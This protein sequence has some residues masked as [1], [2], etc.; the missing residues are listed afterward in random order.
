MYQAVRNR[1][2]DRAEQRAWSPSRSL[3]HQRGAAACRRTRARREQH[4]AGGGDDRATDLAGT[5]RPAQTA[6]H[7]P[8]DQ[9]VDRA[10][11]PSDRVPCGA[12]VAAF[13][14]DSGA[15]ETR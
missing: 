4:R 15:S 11:V 5:R 3:R 7:D 2:R 10:A 8:R 14:D 6:R 1:Q 12:G 13:G 9:V